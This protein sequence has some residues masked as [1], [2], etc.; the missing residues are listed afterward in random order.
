MVAFFAMK[1]N[2]GTITIDDVPKL[3]KEKVQAAIS[4]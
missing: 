1:I 3:W 2:D 4:K